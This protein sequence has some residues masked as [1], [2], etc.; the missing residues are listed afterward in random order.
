MYNFN[1]YSELFKL[2]M[3]INEMLISSA[4]VVFHRNNLIRQAMTGELSCRDPEFAQL[5]QEKINAGME[6]YFSLAQ[7]AARGSLNG[8]LNES[9]K[10]VTRAIKPYHA[11]TRENA[12]RLNKSR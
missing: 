12:K 8:N 7:S 11:K 6:A 9:I 2:G 10:M 5:W 3:Q 4:V 1:T